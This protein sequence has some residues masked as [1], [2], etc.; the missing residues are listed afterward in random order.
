[1]KA[2]ARDPADRY[3]S[4]KD[5]RDEINAYLAGFAPEAEHA[6]ILRRCGLFLARHYINILLILVVVLA[7]ILIGVLFWPDAE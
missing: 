5:L 2:M 3:A 7:V 1:M 6:G 4:V